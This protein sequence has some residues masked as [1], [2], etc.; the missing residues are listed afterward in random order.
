MAF[1]IKTFKTRSLTAAVFVV[2]MLAGLLINQWTFLILFSFIHYGCWTEY[3]RLVGKID[4]DYQSISPFHRNGVIL[5]GY[6]FI[7]WV[8][9]DAFKIG[10]VSLYEIGWWMLIV[11]IIALPVMEIIASNRLNLKNL[12]YSLLGFLYIS[13]TLGLLVNIRCGFGTIHQKGIFSQSYMLFVGEVIC[14]V[15]IITL[16][17][18]DTMAYIVGSLIGRTQFSSIS[19]KKTWEGTIGGALLAIGVVTFV[20]YLIYHEFLSVLFI[21]SIT[22]VFGITGDLFESKLK[23]LAHVKDSGSI[24]PG[25]GG[26]LDRFDSLLFAAPFVWLYVRLLL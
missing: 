26:F 14:I 20:Y 25:H 13:L 15:T 1:N 3:Q 8:T 22:V 23:R 21:S 16:W 6:G 2:I 18:N 7:F 5:I 11:L 4:H 9:N 24:M 17:I 12:G 10:D 19:P